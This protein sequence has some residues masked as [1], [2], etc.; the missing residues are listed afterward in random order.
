M[1]WKANI[2]VQFIAEASLALA[3]Y[4]SGYITKGA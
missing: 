1:L 4:V 2:D 3:Q